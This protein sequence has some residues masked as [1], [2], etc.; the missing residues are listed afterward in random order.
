MKIISLTQGRFT[1][2]DDDVYTWAAKVKWWAS[3]ERGRTYAARTG[4]AG[5]T[6]KLH[7]EIMRPDAEVDVHHINGNGLDNRRNNLQVVTRQ[8][9]RMLTHSHKRCLG[10]SS[11]F[12][13]VDLDNRRR[14]WRARI[15]LDGNETHLGYFEDQETAARAYDRAAKEFFGEFACPNFP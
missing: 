12:R 7:R 3:C 13:G 10:K 8:Q 14:K 15:K 6:I 9:H 5:N 2:V 4:A 11:K 1:V